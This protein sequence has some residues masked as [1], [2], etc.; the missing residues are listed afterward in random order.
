MTNGSGWEW[1][2]PPSPTPRSSAGA[3][4]LHLD[5]CK[6]WG[7]QISLEI[8]ISQS[9]ED[10]GEESA[11]QPSTAAPRGCALLATTTA[12]GLG[13]EGVLCF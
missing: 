4:R 5:L 1:A 13:R 10:R 2:D 8:K 12:V 11:Q 6:A 3:A 7:K 9:S